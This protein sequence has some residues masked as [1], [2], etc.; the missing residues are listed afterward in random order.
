MEE[1]D[2]S[3]LG[4][5]AGNLPTTGLG[6]VAGPGVVL[7]HF[8]DLKA[9]VELKPEQAQEL[10]QNLIAA[11]HSVLMAKTIAGMQASQVIEFAQNGPAN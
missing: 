3:E 5:D 1:R 7:L 4:L 10:G 9:G 2:L 8:F 6:I 11:A